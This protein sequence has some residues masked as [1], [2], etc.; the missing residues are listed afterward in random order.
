V[1]E[2]ALDPARKAAPATTRHSGIPFG[3]SAA[4]FAQL[5]RSM[6]GA[7]RGKYRHAGVSCADALQQAFVKALAKPEKERPSSTNFKGF[8]AWMCEL[9]RNEAMTLRQ[10]DCRRAKREVP[11]EHDRAEMVAMPNRVETVEAWMILEPA[12][13]TLTPEDLA[14]LRALYIDQ[15]TI[16]EIADEQ[17]KRWTTL[18]SQ[19]KR[20]LKLL[21]AAI[22]AAIVALFL[23]PKRAQAFV[24]NILPRVPR[25]FLKTAHVGSTMSVT[26]VC[27]VFLPSGSSRATEATHVMGLTQ[28]ENTTTALA[29]AASLQASERAEVAPEEPKEFDAETNSC[30]LADMKS[31]KF[32]SFLQETVVPLA[33]VVAPAVTQV[34]CAGTEQQTPPARQ[35]D[36]DEEE[37]A[38]RERDDTA[39]RVTCLQAR[40]RGEQCPTREEWD[41]SFLPR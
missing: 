31:T 20:L 18:D 19:H 28:V 40:K 1:D 27:G 3:L 23:T 30:S 14:L 10:T 11:T 13:M 32:A 29:N 17:Q 5:T 35:A 2:A 41:R 33:F 24:K 4:Q 16:A 12:L 34:A 21:Y 6:R 36:D 37:A 38:E 9:A 25:V 8:A 39:Y 26:V 15:K 7:V 22:Q